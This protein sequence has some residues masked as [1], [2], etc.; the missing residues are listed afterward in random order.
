MGFIVAGSPYVPHLFEIIFGSKKQSQPTPAIIKTTFYGS[1][2][3]SRQHRP[4]TSWT[5][6]QGQDDSSFNGTTE[7]YTRSDPLER[8]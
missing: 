1:N 4:G 8:V 2:I 6:L 5:I 3:S 7:A